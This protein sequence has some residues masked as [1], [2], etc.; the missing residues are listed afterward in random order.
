[1]TLWNEN[2]YE[3]LIDFLTFLPGHPAHDNNELPKIVRHD[4]DKIPN[5]VNSD[6]CLRITF[7]DMKEYGLLKMVN[8]DMEIFEGV[9]VD[10]KGSEMEGSQITLTIDNGQALVSLKENDII[11][12]YSN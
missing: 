10:A 11:I 2:L 6:L 3:W 12:F 5:N 7:K 4:C 1:M 9:L 8:G